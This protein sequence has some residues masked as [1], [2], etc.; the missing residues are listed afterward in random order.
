MRS[1]DVKLLKSFQLLEGLAED[2]VDKLIEI[3]EVKQF[4]K[5]EI[6]FEEGDESRN[7]Y[8][9]LEGC[10]GVRKRI[11]DEEDD[12]IPFLPVIA[13]TGVGET[14]GEFSF[15]DGNPRS[16][17][18]F[19]MI[20]TRALVLSPETFNRFTN[21][22]PRACQK[23]T[24][25]LVRILIYRMRKTSKQLSIALEWGWEVRGFGK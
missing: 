24:E 17:E 23:I 12:N 14:V 9:V 18:V 19:A 13:E 6:L 7:I 4:T 16:A 15:F 21:E 10:L 22:F 1:S 8:L 3:S 5:G 2:E 25:N 20:N 11:I